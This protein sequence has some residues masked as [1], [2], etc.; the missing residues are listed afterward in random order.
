MSAESTSILPAH[1]SGKKIALLGPKTPDFSSDLSILDCRITPV[2][3]ASM[4]ELQKLVVDVDAFAID[5]SGVEPNDFLVQAQSLLQVYQK[6]AS[7]RH[8]YA[9][10]PYAAGAPE[11]DVSNVGGPS[12]RYEVL[13]TPR[14][15]YDS[16]LAKFA[17]R[18]VG[19]YRNSDGVPCLILRL[20]PARQNL[21]LVTAK[22]GSGKT[23]L[24]RSLKNRHHVFHTS[25]DYLLTS[26]LGAD[27]SATKS[28][29]LRD[30]LRL[31]GDIPENELWSKFFRR[32]E[33][34]PYHLQCFLKLARE[35]M[36]LSAGEQL[37]SFDIDLRSEKARNVAM[38]FFQQEGYKVWAC[39]T[40]RASSEAGLEVSVESGEGNKAANQLGLLV[41]KE[42]L[43]LAESET[44]NELNWRR[45]M[46]AAPWKISRWN[47][48]RRYNRRTRISQRS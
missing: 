47:A 10:I 32:V 3:S 12:S 44:L 24:A 18:S 28:T 2:P 40:E 16:L 1:L 23:T 30:I 9:S 14:W 33:A 31:I 42:L 29:E 22:S 36:R 7:N 5:L 34:S 46:L 19:D 38:S 15:I 11:W 41:S 39:W 37:V 48:I 20:L 27:A 26:I 35:H 17:A 25:S 43:H 13:P 45:E 8:C 6:L 21:L 4:A